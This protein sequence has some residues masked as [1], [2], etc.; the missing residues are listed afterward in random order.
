MTF[1]HDLRSRP[2]NRVQ[3]TSDGHRRIWKRSRAHPVATL[4]TPSSGASPESMKGRSS[5]LA[6]K[7]DAT[8]FAAGGSGNGRVGFG[9]MGH[10]WTAPAVRKRSEDPRLKTRHAT[11]TAIGYL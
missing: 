5:A 8:A 1:M 4:T 7:F 3:L 9:A 11:P 10:V 6:Y 2:A